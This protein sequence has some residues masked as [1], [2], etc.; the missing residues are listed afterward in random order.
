MTNLPPV[1]PSVVYNEYLTMRKQCLVC[2]ILLL[3]L[4]FFRG[5]ISFLSEIKFFYQRGRRGYSD[6]DFWNL[7]MYLG[8]V[9]CAGIKNLVLY[10]YLSKKKRRRY[11][12]IGE[13][14]LRMQ[15]EGWAEDPTCFKFCKELGF[16]LLSREFP[17]MW[18]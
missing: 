18:S 4:T 16:R 11:R 8:R 9:V 14:F 12:V 10:K 15:T 7:D 1:S 2:K 5:I 3:P 13:C 17:S 6:R